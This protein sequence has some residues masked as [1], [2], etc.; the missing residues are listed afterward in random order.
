MNSKIRLIQWINFFA[1]VLGLSYL[2]YSGR[3]NLLA[4]SFLTAFLFG[5]LGVNVCLHRLVS[6]RVF[7]TYIWVE[8]PLAFLATLATVG[9]TVGWSALHRYHHAHSDDDLDPHS[10]H[11][12]SAWRAWWGFWPRVVIPRRYA[13]DLLKSPLHRFFHKN[14]FKIIMAYIG[15]LALIDPLWV[16]LFYCMPATYCLHGTSAVSVL[17]HVIGY[18]NFETTDHSRNSWILWIV[19][20]GEG[21]HNNHHRFP[22]RISQKHKWWEIDPAG[23]LIKNILQRKRA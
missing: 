13:V 3:W 22:Q 2:I 18:R 7:S 23:F 12:Q 8:I 14:Y 4:Y 1:T 16:I 21:W 19:S 6:H 9:S 17:G 10:P 15:I 11:T 20:F 5:F